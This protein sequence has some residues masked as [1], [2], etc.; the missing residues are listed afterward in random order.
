M[1][2]RTRSRRGLA[3]IAAVAALALSGCSSGSKD[4]AGSSGS[5]GADRSSSSSGAV[6][7]L[8]KDAAIAALVPKELRS[9]GTIVFASDATAPPNQFYGS[10]S[11][12]MIG[13]EVDFGKQLASI[14][15]LKAQFVNISFDSIIPALQAH[16][17]DVGLSGF[18]DTYERQK[19][20]NFVTY[21]QSG[22]QIFARTADK[23]KVSSLA[24]SCGH[25]VAL[26]GGTTQLTILQNYSKT[27]A[28]EGK[29][30]IQIKVFKN[31]N[32]QVQAVISGQ[33]DVGVQNSA[34]NSYL[35]TQTNGA[36][37][38][39]GAPFNV[40]PWGMAVPKDTGLTDALHKATARLLASPQYMQILK[41]W[42]DTSQA[43]SKSVINGAIN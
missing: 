20:V 27:C 21:A 6:A 42:N 17:F 36:L 12:V 10:N 22:T 9:R 29:K 14:M 33:V 23:G 37:V 4:A 28:K 18:R 1:S 13:N 19:V 40:G 43:I 8:P 31:Q 38:G 26:Q 41:K 3:V 39:E 34:N 5:G 25:S 24:Q 2:A 16:R 15:G 35:K 30:P 32:D 7:L 11:K